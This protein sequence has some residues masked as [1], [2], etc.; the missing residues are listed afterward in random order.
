[1]NN[2]ITLDGYKYATTAD[3]W[4]PVIHKPHT[5]RYTL[6]GQLDVTYGPST[7]TAWE[8]EIVAPVTARS[9]GWGT[10]NTLIA[11]LA[12]KE[13]VNFFDHYGQTLYQVHCLGDQER[14]SLFPNWD[15]PHNVF[16]YLVRLVSE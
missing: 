8:G 2:Y 6:T 10:V 14:R 9:F 5:E 4:R 7:P 11:T 16:Y 13:A 15:D 3:T 12:K 1:M